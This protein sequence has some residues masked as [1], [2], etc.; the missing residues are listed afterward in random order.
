MLYA[1]N[2]RNIIFYVSS[3]AVYYDHEKMD[4]VACTTQSE[5]EGWEQTDK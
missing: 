1:K 2:E 4:T 3:S 5:E